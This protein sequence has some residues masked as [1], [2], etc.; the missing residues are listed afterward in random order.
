MS[1]VWTAFP[2][3]ST[4]GQPAL[5]IKWP[6]VS[7]PCDGLQELLSSPLSHY[8]SNIFLHFEEECL[9]QCTWQ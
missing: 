9:W 8:Q 5:L 2:A 4:F 3:T 7:D 6:E 1:V